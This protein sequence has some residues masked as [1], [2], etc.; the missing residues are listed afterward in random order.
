MLNIPDSTLSFGSLSVDTSIRLKPS[1]YTQMPSVSINVRLNHFTGNQKQSILQERKARLA[2]QPFK[3]YTADGR[4]ADDFAEDHVEEKFE[5]DLDDLMT[6]EIKKTDRNDED[7]A[8]MCR[9]AEVG[10]P[11]NASFGI[12]R[13]RCKK[14]ERAGLSRD[15][16][17]T[18]SASSPQA[19]LRDLLGSHETGPITI[20]VSLAARHH[21]EVFEDY[22]VLTKQVR[23]MTLDGHPRNKW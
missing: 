23:Y 12:L 20:L 8:E 11:N 5:F 22:V 4:K 7:L 2:G 13:F 19:R 1:M 21:Q 9:L 16:L 15:Q 3:M 6:F 10:V 18:F 14:G 17:R